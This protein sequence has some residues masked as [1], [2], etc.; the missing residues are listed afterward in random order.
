MPDAASTQKAESTLEDAIFTFSVTE[1]DDGL[2]ESGGRQRASTVVKF[3]STLS[4]QMGVIGKTRWDCPTTIEMP[5][6][7]RVYG[8]ISPERAAQWSA[9]IAMAASNDVLKSHPGC[10]GAPFCR[11]FAEE[12]V[13]LFSEAPRGAIEASV[14]TP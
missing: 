1:N 10:T 7:Q 2:G 9:A 6:R 3:V 5:L 4:A 14:T 8:L 12:M 13:A 11:R